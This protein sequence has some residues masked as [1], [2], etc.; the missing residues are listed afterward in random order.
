MW[1]MSTWS[2]PCPC[3]I[4]SSPQC[5]VAPEFMIY[6]TFILLRTAESTPLQ[7]VLPPVRPLSNV[8]P[9]HSPVDHRDWAHQEELVLKVGLCGSEVLETN[10]LQWL[11]RPGPVLGAGIG[12]L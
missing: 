9:H 12:T 11:A 6:G 4:I 8:V 10:Y 7:S 3:L 5:P 2:A 1:K